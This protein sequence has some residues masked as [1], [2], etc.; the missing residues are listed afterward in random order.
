MA[1]LSL[2][3]VLPLL[4]LQAAPPAS[5]APPAPRIAEYRIGP[6]DVLA[7]SVWQ[8][9]ELSRTTPV[10]PDGKISL[11]LV[12]DVQAAGLTLMELRESLVARLR[13]FMPSPEVSIILAEMNSFKVSVIGEVKRPERYHLRGPATILDVLAMAGGFQDWASRDRIVVLRPRHGQQG[14]A[15]ERI[16]FE[17]KKVIAPGGESG[18]FLVQADDIIV[19]P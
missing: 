12:N 9:A 3:T 1:V 4:A 2:L 19:V 5:D 16:P 8:N 14:P 15:F 7:I 13:D 6:E 11:P 17:Y 18:N 10:R